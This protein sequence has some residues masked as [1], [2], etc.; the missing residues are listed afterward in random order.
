MPLMKSGLAQDLED[1]F[2]RRPASVAD[3]AAAWAKAYVSYASAAMSSASSAA[4]SA[5]A[6]LAPLTAA[7][8]AALGSQASQAAAAAM[9]QGVVTF[10]QSMVWIG[11][12]AAGMT[13]VPGNMALTNGLSAVFS[14]TSEAS[15]G[16]KGS[17]VADAFDAGAKSVIVNDIPLIQPG[18]P[19]IGPIS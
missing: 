19:I 10:W 18:P 14:D 2:T 1:V 4:V 15:A 3:A 6:G 12:T 7:F 11:A 16:A 5:S 17:R 9:T 13:M 8:T